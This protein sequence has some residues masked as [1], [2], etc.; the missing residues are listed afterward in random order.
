MAY[1]FL[2]VAVLTE[3]VGSS[4]LKFTNGFKRL[5]PTLACLSAYMVAYYSISVSM[6][7]LSLNVAYATWCGA[8]TVLTLI[9]G[10]L[11]YHEK[12]TVQSFLGVVILTA[13]IVLLNNC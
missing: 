3:V 9:C 10:A 1:I 2:T 12:I 7:T 4:L 8:G 11:L 13:G 6:Q 5:L